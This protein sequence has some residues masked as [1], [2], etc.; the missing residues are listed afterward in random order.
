MIRVLLIVM[1]ILIVL[2]ILMVYFIV[3]VFKKWCGFLMVM[4]LFLLLINLVI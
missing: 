3:G 4:I 1:G 2:G